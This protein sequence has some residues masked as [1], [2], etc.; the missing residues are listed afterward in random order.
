MSQSD[1]VNGQRV[2]GA[3]GL[4]TVLFLAASVAC[5]TAERPAADAAFE[6]VG[7][8]APVTP[9]IPWEQ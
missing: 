1:A 3:S 4:L 7:R 5:S 6:S 8:G 9:D 2:R